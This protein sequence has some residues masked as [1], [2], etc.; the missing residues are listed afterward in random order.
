MKEIGL[1]Y[2]KQTKP[3][4]KGPEETTQLYYFKKKNKKSG[5][6]KG[7]ESGEEQETVMESK[8]EAK[9]WKELFLLCWGLR[10]QNSQPGNSVSESSA[11]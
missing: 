2:S 8:A 4:I 7:G 6:I 1:E 9:L 11:P 10:T 5:V 3:Q